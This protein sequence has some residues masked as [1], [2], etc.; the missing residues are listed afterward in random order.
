MIKSASLKDKKLEAYHVGFQLGPR[1]NAPGRMDHATKSY[2]LLV[3]EDK[4][5]AESLASWLSD[6]NE[7]RQ[8]AMEKAET[9]AMNI[10]EKDDLAKNKIIILSGEWPKG[11]IGPT[12]SRIVEKYCRPAILF[13]KDGQKLVGSARG[14]PGIN[15]V[16][17]IGPFEKQLIKFGGHK[18]AAG[19]SVEEKN[20]SAFVKG[21]T[22]L[23]NEQIPDELLVK[24]IFVDAKIKLSEMTNALYDKITQLEPFGMGNSKPV[25]VASGI[26]LENPR[27]VGK[28]EKHLSFLVSDGKDRFKSICF[29]SPIDCSMIGNLKK[30]DIAF[31]LDINTWNNATNLNLNVI[32]VKQV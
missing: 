32:D 8:L 5:E 24:R 29:N 2:E 11:I 27:F 31:N 10:I 6:K 20:Y 1:I 16:E 7:H 4:N 12:A 17:L 30:C 14:V 18:S 23:A 9:E 22:K 15:L 26:A 3:T 19:L 28:M 21:L 13:A 25:F